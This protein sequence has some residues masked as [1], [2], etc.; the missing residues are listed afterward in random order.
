MH[1]DTNDDGGKAPTDNDVALIAESDPIATARR[2]HGATGAILAAGMFGVDIALGRKPKEEAPIVV[3]APTE[4]TDIDDEGI[5]IPID[6][7]TSVYAPPQPPTD[8]FPPRR[9]RKRK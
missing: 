2:R 4:P 9:P 8:P 5:E 1:D 3:A 6:H 7:L